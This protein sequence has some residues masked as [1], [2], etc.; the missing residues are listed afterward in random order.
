MEGGQLAG[1]STSREYFKVGEAG[2][3]AA[4]AA[5]PVAFESLSKAY[6]QVAFHLLL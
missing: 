5:E 4:A 6:R 3:A 1:I 2:G